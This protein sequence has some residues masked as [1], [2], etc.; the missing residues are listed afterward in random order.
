MSFEQQTYARRSI[1]SIYSAKIS[2]HYKLTIDDLESSLFSNF[3]LTL[4]AMHPG[5]MHIPPSFP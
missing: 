5:K 4:L 2:Y 1:F 3:Q